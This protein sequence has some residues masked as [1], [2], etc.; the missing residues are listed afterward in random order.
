M[1]FIVL[2]IALIMLFVA[3]LFFIRLSSNSMDINK[4][5]DL[6]YSDEEE[7]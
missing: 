7:G 1:L 3:C 4:F 6:L 5:I 2:F